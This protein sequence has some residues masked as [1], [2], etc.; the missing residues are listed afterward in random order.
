MRLRYSR[1]RL[2]Y[3]RM[4][5]KCRGYLHDPALLGCNEARDI[6]CFDVLKIAVH[7]LAKLFRSEYFKVIKFN[8][9]RRRID[10]FKHIKVLSRAIQRSSRQHFTCGSNY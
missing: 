5:Q 1:M 4:W 8:F 7:A 6:D 10:L 3:S 9:S 2:K